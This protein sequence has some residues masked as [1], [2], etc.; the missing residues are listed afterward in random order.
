MSVLNEKFARI[1]NSYKKTMIYG[2]FNLNFH[3]LHLD[4]LV[5]ESHSLIQLLNKPN[6]VTN[7][8]E[9][10]IDNK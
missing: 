8:S 6:R 2:D 7:L 3:K 4:A 5:A 10:L 1:I 9:T